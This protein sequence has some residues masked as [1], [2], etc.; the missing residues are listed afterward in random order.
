MAKAGSWESEPDSAVHF[1][2][3]NEG[4]GDERAMFLPRWNSNSDRILVYILNDRIYI[5]E[6]IGSDNN[7]HG[8][9]YLPKQAETW[10]DAYVVTD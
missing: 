10:Y 3:Y 1:S 9:V 4:E 6:R 8:Q 5:R 2:Y 7:W